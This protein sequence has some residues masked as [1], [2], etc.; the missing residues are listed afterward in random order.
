MEMANGDGNNFCNYDWSNIREC[1][2]TTSG[3]VKDYCQISCGS[4]T[5]G[6]FPLATIYIQRK[7]LSNIY[8]GN[9]NKCIF[10]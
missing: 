9:Y 8:T 1:V 7:M 2:P 10:F 5:C 6:K 4:D 3:K